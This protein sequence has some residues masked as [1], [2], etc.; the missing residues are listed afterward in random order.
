M[1][2]SLTFL[3]LISLP[4]GLLAGPPPDRKQSV[5]PVCGSA[6]SPPYANPSDA[7]R[8]TCPAR[9]SR[10]YTTKYR[11]IG[12][13]ILDLESEACF[14]PDAAYRLLDDIVDEVISRLSQVRQS[15]I[16]QV[17]A[18]SKTTG[19]V[20]AHRGFGLYIPT[21]TLGDALHPRNRPGES[22]RHIFDC[23]TGSMILLTIAEVLSTPASLVEIT[24][25]SGSSHNY[26]RWQVDQFTSIDWDTNGR[27]Q[28]LTPRNTPSFQ[29][30]SMSR[31]EVISYALTLRAP[32]WERGSAARAIDDYFEAMKRS[33]GHPG[34]QN[35]FAWLIATKEFSDRSKYKAMAIDAATKAVALHRIPNYM[36]T[37]ACVHAFAG[38]FDLAKRYAE[39]AVAGAP[40][41]TQFAQRLKL[42][43]AANPTDCTG[44]D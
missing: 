25:P 18:I 15:N 40:S 31:S 38:E 1:F 35:N 39:E 19:D 4:T 43:Q 9:N 33:P 30:K 42:F 22:P 20:L 6:Y 21:E 32:L 5:L 8:R 26:V 23:D 10:G 13:E 28:C 36:D 29:G 41:N 2:R 27:G 44:S 16:E 34:P 12:F 14:V 11:G 3:L 37:L 17:L 7:G 24:L